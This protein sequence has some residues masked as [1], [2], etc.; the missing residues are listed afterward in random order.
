MEEKKKK[1]KKHGLR[2]II[3]IFL[4][5]YGFVQFYLMNFNGVDTVKALEGY[6]NDSVIS[7]GIVCRQETVLNKTYDGYV[8]YLAADG[9]RVSKG[10]LIANVYPSQSDVDNLIKLRS[11][12]TLMADINSVISY[13]T[14]NTLDISV[15]RKSLT[16]QLTA[17]SQKTAYEDYSSISDDLAAL[18]FS[19]NKINVA[20]G[21]ITDFSGGASLI[22]SEIDSVSA[23]INSPS[24][25]LYAPATGYFIN[26]TDGYESVATVD[27]FW[28][29]DAR[30]GIDIIKNKIY[31]SQNTGEYGKI[32]TD[33]KWS[34][35]T[36][37]DKADGENLYEGKTVNISISAGDNEFQKATVKKIKEFD[38]KY[39]VVIEC[40]IMS[41]RSATARITE[42][43]ILNKQYK[44][45]KI[46]KSAIH[47]EN[48]EMGVYV[49]FSNIAQFKKIDPI[50]EDSNYV[51]V[52]STTSD[53]NQVK[54]YDS[55]IVKG[56]N[57]YDGK[58]L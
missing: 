40:T 10:E 49:N 22:Q 12:Q 35:C 14:G 54:L 8:D 41:S 45:I 17:M 11:K 4:V 47:F 48:G 24:E 15:T 53:D 51:V 28:N 13:T 44:G 7:P 21:K 38:D 52:P 33:Y 34:L 29:I 30:R 39:L 37:I 2:S 16:N 32:I 43:E 55:I 50:F 27:N 20:T 26:N 31:S 56:R 18:A 6:I 9:R 58:Y 19:I 57:L 3:L 1:R 42:C 46:P 23:G 36:Y 5:I 25:N